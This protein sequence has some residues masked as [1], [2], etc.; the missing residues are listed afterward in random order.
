MNIEPG[1][2]LIIRSIP[3]Y[4]V[5]TGMLAEFLVSLMDLYDPSR[6]DMI[7]QGIYNSL[8]V[9][10]SKGVIPSLAP[11]FCTTLDPSL[12]K[13]II[14]ALAPFYR[15]CKTKG[16]IQEPLS[17]EE[18]ESLAGKLFEKSIHIQ[19]ENHKKK[20]ATSNTKNITFH[21]I[22]SDENLRKISN[23]LMAKVESTPE[24]KEE[25]SE[26][27]QHQEEFADEEESNNNIFYT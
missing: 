21:R 3:K 7:K 22:A 14:N 27:E 15:D 18:L 23:D 26:S 19:L 11:L 16:E 20:I 24:M 10:L 25:I 9:M 6:K 2:L 13:R 4:N 5:I 1:M 8:T 12:T 17:N